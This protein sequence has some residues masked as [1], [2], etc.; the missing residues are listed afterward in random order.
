VIN[1]V[2]HIVRSIRK[3]AATIVT[4]A[5]AAMVMSILP[6][7]T[8]AAWKIGAIAGASGGFA[9]GL[10]SGG[11]IKAAI[12]GAI[13]GGLSGAAAGWVAHGTGIAAKGAVG[14]FGDGALKQLVHGVTQGA[15]AKLRGG[16]F[17]SGFIGAIVGKYADRIASRINLDLIG[18]K[19]GMRAIRTAVAGV[20]GG[21]AAKMIGGRFGDGAISAAFRWLFNEELSTER[22][23]EMEKARLARAQAKMDRLLEENKPVPFF[24]YENL[25]GSHLRSWS[26]MWNRTPTRGKAALV[27]IYTAYAAL[28]TPEA[29]GS[30]TY[31][32]TINM[33]NRMLANPANTN[34]FIIDV[35]GS[36]FS[37]A[38]PASS[39]AGGLGYAFCYTMSCDNLVK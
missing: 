30:M 34:R 5:V 35:V 20:V 29:V 33:S 26:I 25:I 37:G 31:T 14:A 9:G 10:T 12:K 8:M 18:A 17:K 19:M 39:V 38:A 28:A 4:I 22:F 15:I 11:G 16:D 27:A 24:S 3:Y 13:F 1:V 36:G 7:A 6:T 32:Q 2:K 21:L 23:M